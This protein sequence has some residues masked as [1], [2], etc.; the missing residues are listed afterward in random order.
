MTHI[1]IYIAYSGAAGE[2]A[3]RAVERHAVRRWDEITVRYARDAD[4]RAEN[5]RQRLARDLSDSDVLLVLVGADMRQPPDRIARA[6]D[7]AE[8]VGL[9]ILP[10]RL[11]R[12][13]F[14]FDDWPPGFSPRD[15]AVPDRDGAPED[16]ARQLHDI[17]E[18]ARALLRRA[19]PA[20][21]HLP[22][23]QTRRRGPS[24]FE[25]AE[26]ARAR[27]GASVHATP[28]PAAIVALL[29]S[30]P[31]DNNPIIASP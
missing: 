6:I 19:R 18:G 28:L 22:D 8:T 12:A 10:V 30:A 27:A 5:W 11:D 13:A 7:V 3:A 29:G 16:C 24:Q 15:H 2:R 31:D 17:V 23:P 20:T 21:A 9:P 14:S 26:F 4:A 1:R 25:L